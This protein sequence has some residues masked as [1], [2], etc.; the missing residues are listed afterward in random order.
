M[1]G[2]GKSHKSL[3]VILVIMTL[4]VRGITEIIIVQEHHN[5]SIIIIKDSGTPIK[6]IPYEQGNMSFGTFGKFS[7]FEEIT[8]FLELNRNLSRCYYYNPNYYLLNGLT[9]NVISFF[10]SPSST[11]SVAVEYSTTNIQVEGVDEGDIVKND[12]SYAYITS[13]DT[14]T[15]VIIK[16]VPAQR[17]EIVS[18]IEVNWNIKEIY[19]NQDSLVVLGEDSHSEYYYLDNHSTY[20]YEQRTCINIYDIK[21][22]ENPALVKSYYVN[23]GIISSRIIGNHLYLITSQSAWTLNEESDLPAPA[24]K[25][26]YLN[27]YDSSYNFLTLISLNIQNHLEKPNSIAI[28]MGQAN[29]IFV[30]EHNIYLTSPKQLS[31]IEQREMEIREVEAK[32]LPYNILLTLKEISDSDLL[33]WEKVYKINQ[34][35]Q[36]FLY[37]LT[38]Q[39]RQNYD[40]AWQQKSSEF[41][42]LIYNRTEQ[43][44]IHKIAIRGGTLHYLT[45]G[46]VPGRVLNRFSMDEHEG[47][48]RIA[49]TAGHVSRNGGLTSRN[50][51][52]VLDENLS[53]IGSIEDLAPGEQIYSARFMGD[54]AY[55]VTFKKVDPFFVVDLSDPETPQILGQLKIPGYSNYLHPYDENFVIGIGKDCYDMGGFVW[56]QG[57]KISLFNVSDVENPQ[58]IAKFIIGDRGTD[59]ESLYD[60]HA[61]LFSKTKDLLVLPILLAEI[62]D[63]SYET[64]PPPQTYGTF[65]WNGAYVLNITSGNGITLKGR[66]SHELTQSDH[67]IILY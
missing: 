41:Q 14:K 54:R 45:N 29:Q 50:Q 49:T 9:P 59:S 4:L 39:G 64:A 52:Y 20:S 2:I 43:T 33:R 25:I 23:G 38:A 32:I 17:L 57:V 44:Q 37:Q 15:V 3:V 36:T 51:L 28:L 10:S 5:A 55:L 67:T 26:L 42:Q 30:S 34:L 21:I 66:I 8:K 47:D 18:Q 12:D 11:S 56:Y 16:L 63:A 48:F 31:Y 27:E 35:I 24:D 40:L 19:L 46:Y 13:P 53:I 58:E 65:T 22:R 1:F 60:P 6:I 62:N 7:N 61:F